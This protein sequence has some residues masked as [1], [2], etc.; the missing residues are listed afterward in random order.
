M[1]LNSEQVKQAL[2]Q[3]E[4]QAIPDNHPAVAQLND[5][6]GE[7]TFFLNGSGLHVLQAAASDGAETQTGA[8]V[9]LANWSNDERTSL[10]PHEPE[11]TGEVVI[12]EPTTH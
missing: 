5:I 4:A 6:F 7:H 12:L 8:V 10:T 2:T 9:N 1:K 3:F 11:P